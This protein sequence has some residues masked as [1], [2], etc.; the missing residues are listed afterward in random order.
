MAPAVALAPPAVFAHEAITT[1]LTWTRE[2]SRVVFKHC[3]GC[4]HEGGRAFSLLTYEEARPWAKAIQEEVLERRMPPWGAVKGYGEFRNDRGLPGEEIALLSDWVEGGAPDGEPQ[5]LPPKPKFKDEPRRGRRQA[6][7]VLTDSVRLAAPVVVDG[8][9]AD[10]LAKGDSMRIY[11]ELPTGAVEPLVW[12]RGYDARFPTEYLLREP[13]RLPGGSRLVLERLSGG[14]VR[15][16][17]LPR[18]ARAARSR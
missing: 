1:K 5:Y 7:M 18:L 9:R 2:I 15:I 8:L 3:A 14:P 6:A 12:L 4:H 17:V 16:A 10:R 11:A 13:L